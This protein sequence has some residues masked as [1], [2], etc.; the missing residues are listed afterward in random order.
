MNHSPQEKKKITNRGAR[1]KKKQ[2]KQ[3]IVVTN[4]GMPLNFEAVLVHEKQHRWDQ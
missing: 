4:C 1:K 2:T 3:T